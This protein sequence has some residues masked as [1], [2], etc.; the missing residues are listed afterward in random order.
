MEPSTIVARALKQFE[1]GKLIL[2][3]D[4]WT[5]LNIY[6]LKLTDLIRLIGGKLSILAPSSFFHW[7]LDGEGARASQKERP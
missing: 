5:F 6:T 4:T 7:F 1:R 3:P 2:V